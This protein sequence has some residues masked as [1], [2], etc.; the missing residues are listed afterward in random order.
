MDD[1][2]SDFAA[3]TAAQ[4][5][6]AKTALAAM[7]NGGEPRALM[8]LLHSVKG[9]CG[10]L[11]LTRLEALAHAG[12]DA[13]TA[14]PAAADA[15]K[16]LLDRMATLLAGISTTGAEPAGDD[17][18]LLNRLRLAGAAETALLQSEH[19]AAV[20]PD[21]AQAMRAALDGQT[22]L[23]R[24]FRATGA[25]AED[26]GNRLGKRLCFTATGGGISVSAGQAVALKTILIQLVRN[27]ADHGVE[28]ADV[29]LKAGKPE[30]GAI[31]VSARSGGGVLMIE[32]ADDGA[33]LDLKALARAAGGAAGMDARALQDLVFAPGLTTKAEV[34][35]LSGRGAGLDAAKAEV[36]ALGGRI[37]VDST[38]GRGTRFTIIIPLAAPADE[39]Q[40]A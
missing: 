12:E 23:E 21:L 29:R 39:E 38:A 15:L 10:F 5:V 32:L 7:E 11:G 22:P 36:E 4:L 30:T 28:S 35:V 24:V 6:A 1:L 31:T 40:A 27:A 19:A 18:D 34:S 2:V 37:A 17:A 33:G 13:L 8:R 25:A 14:G 20:L 9:G 16:D 26:A 3:E